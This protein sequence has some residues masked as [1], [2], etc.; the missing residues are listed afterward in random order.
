MRAIVCA[1][2]ASNLAS[3]ANLLRALQDAG[4]ELIALGRPDSGVDRLKSDFGIPF[5][6]VSMNNTGMNALDDVKTLFSFLSIYRKQKPDIALHFNSK[7]DIYGS[8]A[9]G[10][11]G[12]PSLCNITGLGTVYSGSGGIVRFLVNTLYR[13]AFSGKQAFVFFQNADDLRLFMEL[14]ILPRE[15]A[16][17]LP[18]SGVDIARFGPVD[19]SAFPSRQ[20]SGLTRFLFVGRMLVSKGVTDFID[21]A[22]IVKASY[23]H[24]TFCMVGETGDS[25]A[26]VPRETIDAAVRDGFVE[27]PGNVANVRDYLSG[28]DCVVLPSYY[29][30]GVPRSLLEAASMATPLIAC[31]S[32]GTREPVRDGEN[33]YLCACASPEDLAEKMIRFICLSNLEKNAM[34]ER[35]RMIAE[36]DFSDTIVTARYLDVIKKGRLE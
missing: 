17:I 5:I 27:Y 3:R 14:R 25:G 19:R 32:V 18:G 13:M 4:Y 16:G 23:P 7:P 21:A 24:S 35:S 34:G 15:K 8:M 33:G 11:L 31:D 26:F 20:E 1:N 6:P 28:A 9:A 36:R 10:F 22:R 29:R 30:E 12:I 2:L